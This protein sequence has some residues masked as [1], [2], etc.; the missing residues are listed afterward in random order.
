M[1]SITSLFDYFNLMIGMLG[2]GL[3]GVFVLAVFTTRAHWLGAL[4]GLLSG[5]VATGLVQLSS[6][7]HVYLAGAAGTVTCVAVGY[8][9]SWLIPALQK[10]L[11]G[12]TI[13]TLRSA[14]SP[15]DDE[16]ACS[17]SLEV[18]TR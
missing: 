14:P 13:H 3:A 12:L 6:S 1:S 11:T 16:L 2:G 7:I 5:A 8:L 15:T 4:I 10:D 18:S 9:A 17:E